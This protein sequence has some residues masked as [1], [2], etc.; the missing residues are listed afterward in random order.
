M[1]KVFTYP[2]RNL[3]LHLFVFDNFLT[4]HLLSASDFI[5]EQIRFLWGQHKRVSCIKYIY[6][7]HHE[8]ELYGLHKIETMKRLKLR[9]LFENR[10]GTI[11]C[12]LCQ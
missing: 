12:I 1:A 2:I 8:P 9:Y 11:Y 7:I 4:W 5:A 10:K 6:Q 3:C